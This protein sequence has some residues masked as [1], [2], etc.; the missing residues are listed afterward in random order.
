M[1]PS[2][3][4]RNLFPL[5]FAVVAGTLGLT[6]CATAQVPIAENGQARAVIVHNGFTDTPPQYRSRN[7]QDLEFLRPVNILSHYLGKATGGEFEQ[8]ETIEEA[9]DR[10]A[11]VFDFVDELDGVS[12][13]EATANQAYR[14]RTEDN[15]LLLQATTELGMA[16]AVLGLLL[17]HLDCRFYGI[18]KVKKNQRRPALEVVPEH[19][20]LVLEG[21]DDLQEPSF[22]NRGEIFRLGN[23]VGPAM[24][25]AAGHYA[26][27]NGAGMWAR[28][29]LYQVLDA[30]ETFEEHPDIFPMSAEGEHFL[31]HTASITGSNPKTAEILAEKLKGE[32]K[33][34]GGFKSAGQGDGFEPSFAPGDRE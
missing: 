31:P 18:K 12:D 22:A 32:R 23:F 13:R 34:A 21:I 1:T 17:D 8:V 7:K 26:D 2:T 20:T 27:P 11:I 29:N 14:I 4:P 33:F 30:K 24:N 19:K 28:H 5:L 3:H 15:R 16:N 25:R 6:A 10:P 9:G